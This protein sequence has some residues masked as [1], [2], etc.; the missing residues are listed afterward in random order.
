MLATWRKRLG[1]GDTMADPDKPIPISC[2]NPRC[3]QPNDV[4]KVSIIVQEG[5]TKGTVAQEGTTKG[6]NAGKYSITSQ[7]EL[8]AAL[9]APAEPQRVW[10]AGSISYVLLFY[11]SFG[12]L[13]G[14]LSFILFSVSEEFAL[15]NG[16]GQAVPF[17]DFIQT[18]L[19]S[20]SISIFFGLI[21]FGP[22]LPYRYN[23][24]KWA[25]K[26]ALWDQLYYCRRCDSVFNPKDP[27][28]TNPPDPNRTFV[29]AKD[30]K[31]LLV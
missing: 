10:K 17:G 19:A 21:I 15:L 26:K 12:F 6:A 18:L 24:A 16:Q 11:L 29:P 31:K 9:A 28:D 22:E 13:L 25:K 30:I 1:T 23:H 14:L 27:K 20:S 4:Q 7:N 2:P 8:S 3:P 5:T